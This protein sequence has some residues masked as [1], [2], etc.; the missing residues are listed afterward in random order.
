MAMKTYQGSCHCQK[1]RFQA[2]IDLE[3]GTGKCNCSFCAKV[4]DWIV[5]IKPEAFQLLSDPQ[6]L[7]NYGFQEESVNRHLFCKHCGVRLYTKGHVPEMG[8]D[9]VS[10]M[11]SAL[12]GISDEK[13]AALPVQFFDGRHDNWFEAPPVTS[14]L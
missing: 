14:H 7:G 4:R 9:F 1:V 5:L 10:V 2:D 6:H 11:V 3:A 12:D 8:G 13:L